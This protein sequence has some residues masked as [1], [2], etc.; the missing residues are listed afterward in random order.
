[1]RGRNNTRPTPCGKKG[2]TVAFCD[3]PV[4]FCDTTTGRHRGRLSPSDQSHYASMSI[5]SIR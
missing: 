2:H 4:A 5:K 1:M 3:S